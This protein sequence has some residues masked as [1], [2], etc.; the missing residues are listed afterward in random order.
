MQSLRYGSQVIQK[1]RAVM[2]SF[3]DRWHVVPDLLVGYLAPTS[4]IEG[5]A[6]KY[7]LCAL[8]SL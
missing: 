6:A 4:L 8:L 3:F 1:Y 5:T 7:D 2:Q